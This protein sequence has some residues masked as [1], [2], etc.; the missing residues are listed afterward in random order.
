MWCST[1]EH[2]PGPFGPWQLAERLAQWGSYRISGTTRF[3]AFNL[4]GGTISSIADLHAKADW[5]ARVVA[6]GARPFLVVMTDRPPANKMDE[7]PPKSMG[8]RPA[9]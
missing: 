3:A 5:F 2:P 1:T 8:D 4:E 7:Q 6:T 9:A